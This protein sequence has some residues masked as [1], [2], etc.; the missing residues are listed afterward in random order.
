MRGCSPRVVARCGSVLALASLAWAA[1]SAAPGEPAE[2]GLAREIMRHLDLD[3]SAA[4]PLLSRG[5]IVHTGQRTGGA[6][7]E[8]VSAVGAMLVVRGVPANQVVEAFL[9]ADT[10]RRVHQVRRF[11]AIAA[12]ADPA[13]IYRELSI[14]D[15]QAAEQLLTLPSRY[16]NVSAAEAGLALAAKTLPGDVQSRATRVVTEILDGRL[17]SFRARGLAGLSPYLRENGATVSPSGELESAVRRLGFLEKEYPALIE[18]LLQPASAQTQ[19]SVGR[20]LFW[21]ET[22]FQGYH[23]LTLASELREQGRLKALAADLHFYATRAYNSMLTLL[24][25]VP[26]GEDALVFAINHTF[27]DEVLGFGSSLKRSVARRQVGEQL[28]RH[29]EEVRRR[30]PAASKG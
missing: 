19:G 24:G 6:L 17:A 18:A 20:K 21:L 25:V 14:G 13:E 10:F 8:E 11:E 12:T 7:P 27:T 30:L 16:Y 2:I 29:L 4:E 1:T 5:E 23:V 26:Y 15:Q 22:P 3:V 9:D 28:V